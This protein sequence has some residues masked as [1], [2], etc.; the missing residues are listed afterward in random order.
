MTESE[1]L[2]LASLPAGRE[3]DE[4]VARHV[5]GWEW[6]Y[7]LGNGYQWKASDG[8]PKGMYWDFSSQMSCAAI[9]LDH[10]V[11][12][13]WGPKMAD[14]SSGGW[15]C[16]MH[17]WRTETWSVADTLPLAICRAALKAALYAKKEA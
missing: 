6:G 2:R 15:V 11:A 4:A 17:K 8:K 13:G 12:Q 3:L 14:S 5:L 10:A 9:V 7:V 16:T 1:I